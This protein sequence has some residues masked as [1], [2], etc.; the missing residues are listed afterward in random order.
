MKTKPTSSVT[1]EEAR[2]PT[3]ELDVP[4]TPGLDS[5]DQYQ[6]RHEPVWSDLIQNQQRTPSTSASEQLIA[7]EASGIRHTPPTLQRTASRT[8]INDRLRNAANLRSCHLSNV[9]HMATLSEN[10]RE[11][12]IEN[13][14]VALRSDVGQLTAALERHDTVTT[15]TTVYSIV[16]TVTTWLETIEYRVYLI[17][18]QSA[19]GPSET[20]VQS[21]TD[22]SSELQHIADNVQQVSQQL[23][24]AS[25]FVPPVDKKRM[26]TSFQA[27]QSQVKAIEEIAK[28]NEEQARHDLTRWND[29][30]M[31][32]EQIAIYMNNLQEQFSAIVTDDVAIEE[33]LFMLDELELANREQAKEIAK[34]LNT[35]RALTR[36]FPDKQPQP[37][38]DAYALHELSKNLENNIYLQRNQLLQMQSLAE[39][40]EQ[41]LHE[42]AQSTEM[43]DRLV[44]KPIIAADLD[45]LQREVQVHH[46][47]FVNLSQCR[48]IL[49]SMDANLDRHTRDQHADMHRRLYDRATSILERAADRAHRLSRAASHWTVLLMGMRDERQWLQ[50]A[51]QRVPDLSAVTSADYDHYITMYQSLRSDISAHH[52]KQHQLTASAA[53]LQTLCTAPNVADE[54]NDALLEVRRLRE[55]V[56]G[57][58]RR[59]HAFSETWATYE[60]LTDRLELW[61]KDAERDIGQLQQPGQPAAASAASIEHMRRFWEIKIHY[62]VHNNIRTGIGQHFEQAMQIVPLADEMLQRQFL[63]QLDDRWT[64]VSA[65]IRAIQ[66]AV[67]DTLASHD[68]PIADKLPLLERELREL[69]LN[70]GSAKGVIRNEDELNLYIERMQVLQSRAQLIG[71]ELGRISMLAAAVDADAD[72]KAAPTADGPERIGDLFGL[73]HGVSLQ[74]AEELDGTALVKDQIGR[75]RQ[76]IVRVRRLQAAD[77]AALDECEAGERASS[78]QLEQAVAECQTVADGLAER[79]QQ[80]MELRQLLHTLPGGQLRMTVS[81]VKLERDIARLQDEHAALEAR[82]AAVL[83]VLRKRLALWRRFERQLELVQQ[84]VQQTDYMVELLRVD[85]HIDYERLRQAT[86]RLEVSATGNKLIGAGHVE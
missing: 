53:R 22:L 23:K 21:F 2:S 65:K 14:I 27:L 75:I 4:L 32:C 31:L 64:A 74:I 82:C 56:N 77:A 50:V 9:L 37:Q 58:L 12:P 44:E 13:R 55:E 42:F 33:K 38:Q 67:V 24:T 3:E 54:N 10:F 5:A 73:S 81:P 41:T 29:Y 63:A 8:V 11:E 15:Q 34:L 68:T 26:A 40:Y 84:S 39:M 1:I 59:L 20:K 16:E 7:A 52:A 49:E 60:Q 45:E 57:Y 72:A 6:T 85:G 78:A 66:A 17:R 83:A 69:Q 62:E 70:L 61:I 30:V 19:E 18:Q 35:A 28:E 51:Q 76:G 79:W 48:S 80:I 46:K 47:F 36:D 25:E 71:T 86:E 43:A